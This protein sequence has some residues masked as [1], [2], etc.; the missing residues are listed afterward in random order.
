MRVC[1]IWDFELTWIWQTSR[2]IA[3]S[4]CEGPCK[5]VMWTASE[6]AVAFESRWSAISFGIVEN[7]S[8]W[9]SWTGCHWT[10][11]SS[12]QPH[13]TV[14]SAHSTC[15]FVAASSTAISTFRH[16][17]TVTFWRPI[18]KASISL[19]TS[20]TASDTG[21]FLAVNGMAAEAA[22]DSDIPTSQSER[23]SPNAGA[24]KERRMYI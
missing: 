8:R 5:S 22:S 7:E 18:P 13:M 16:N 11:A 4:K 12:F 10:Q 19:A 2:Q 1:G 14:L 23:P 24:E 21:A 9:Q 6:A 17:S 3:I 20:A 15:F